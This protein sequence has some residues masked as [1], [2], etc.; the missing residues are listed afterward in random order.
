MAWTS[1]TYAFLSVLTSTKMTQLF[2]NLTAL[3]QGQSGAPQIANAQDIG[4]K[5]GSDSGY[6]ALID[7][8]AYQLFFNRT[9]TPA[10]PDGT[11]ASW[12]IRLGDT[13]DSFAIRRS[14]SG[15]T[16]LTD[17]VVFDSAG[18]LTAGSVPLARLGTSVLDGNTLVTGNS[19]SAVSIQSPASA[20]RF[21]VLSI[22]SNDISGTPGKWAQGTQVTTGEA[23]EADLHAWI[24]RS[25]AGSTNDELVLVNGSGTSQTAYYKIY[26]LTET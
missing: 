23:V 5:T 10:Q 18:K 3:A 20:H 11:K 13:A 12:G 7:D 25:A 17:L 2:D 14:P 26:E 9:S 15:S 4:R 1:L 21:Y 6:L 24:Q 16:T 19:S 8:G 22:R